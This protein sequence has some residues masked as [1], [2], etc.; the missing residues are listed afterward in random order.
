MIQYDQNQNETSEKSIID[1]DYKLDA[2][3]I[4]QIASSLIVRTIYYLPFWHDYNK[5]MNEYAAGTVNVVDCDLAYGLLLELKFQVS[6]I[7][8]KKFTSIRRKE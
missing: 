2:I 4:H 3:T 5:T 7:V 6:I 1:G 8:V